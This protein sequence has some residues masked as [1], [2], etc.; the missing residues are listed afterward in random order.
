MSDDPIEVL[1]HPALIE[2]FKQWLGQ[3]GLLLA[4]MPEEMQCED[5]LE[6]FFVTPTDETMRRMQ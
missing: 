1:L 5:G 3:R 2:P 6:L 4:R